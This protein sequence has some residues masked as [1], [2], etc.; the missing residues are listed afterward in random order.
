MKR[1]VILGKLAEIAGAELSR[2]HIADFGREIAAIE[3]ERG[4]AIILAVHLETA[5]QTALV[6]RLKIDKKHFGDMFG[7]NGPMGT[8]DNKV[9]MASAIGLLTDETRSYLDVIRRI[10]NAFAHSMV[11]I[12]FKTREVLNACSLLKVPKSLP[13]TTIRTSEG[14][15]PRETYQRTCE[16][17]AHNL[18]VAARMYVRMSPVPPPDSV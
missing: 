14:L 12:S 3:N 18:F 4:A 5:L 16:T 2:E 1:Q 13:P 6:K 10:R 8:F 17:I 15:S 9:R 7:F 11:P